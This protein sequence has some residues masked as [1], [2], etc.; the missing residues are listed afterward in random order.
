MALNHRVGKLELVFSTKQ[1][2]VFRDKCPVAWSKRFES[3]S[4]EAQ[5]AVKRLR[6]Y[7]QAHGYQTLLA[8]TSHLGHLLLGAIMHI[9]HEQDKEAEDAAAELL[10]LTKAYQAKTGDIFPRIGFGINPDDERIARERR[11]RG[12]FEIED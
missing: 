11:E 9:V 10:P 4:P 2:Q 1:K 3:S 12:L 8:P 5:H 7:N 6:A